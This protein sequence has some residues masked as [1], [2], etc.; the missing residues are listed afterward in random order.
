MSGLTVDTH[1]HAPGFVPAPAARAYRWINRT[2]MPPDVGFDDVP[3]GGVDA[4]VAKAVGDPIAT[5]WWLRS[6]WD[7]VGTQ[8]DR[9]EAEARRAGARVVSDVGEV[10]AAHASNTLAVILGLEGADAIGED[11]GKLDDL[12]RRGVR[13][14]V[15]VHL[16]NNQL[17]TTCL[18]WQNYVGDRLPTRRRPTGLTSLGERA[19]DRMNDLG[20]VIDVSHAD[21]TTTRDIIRRSRHPVIASHAGAR[22][23]QDF[24]RYLSDDLL[25]AIANGASG[26]GVIGL[27]PYHHRGR[28]V[29]DAAE[30]ARHA[31]HVADRYG[32]EHLCLG[33][34]L[35]GIPGAMEGY[36]GEADVPMIIDALLEAGFS[37]EEVDGIR[38]ENFLRVFEAV[39]R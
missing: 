15:P 11:L 4:I 32:P 20:I 5:R 27:W 38:G 39:T 30:L 37:D 18:P 26:G 29:R 14:V 33:T 8:L 35:N 17:G 19:V 7:A 3:K 28:G 22:A 24:P 21:A 34:D 10:R 6:A 36:E 1:T 13:V 9:I 16:A 12:H 2:T 23:L 25:E 31:R